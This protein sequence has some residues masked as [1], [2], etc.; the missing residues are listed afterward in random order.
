MSLFLVARKRTEEPEKTLVC[1]TRTM[2]EA[3]HFLLCFM[4]AAYSG[5]LQMTTSQPMPATVRS[6]ASRQKD[7]LCSEE[8]FDWRFITW[9]SV[10]PQGKGS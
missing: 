4:W 5:L 9:C 8:V 6:S 2:L 10:V 7:N 1:R 3:T